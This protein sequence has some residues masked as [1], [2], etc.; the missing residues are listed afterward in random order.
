MSLENVKLFYARVAV[1]E[2]FRAQIQQLE[3]REEG[4][5]LA[6]A[7]GFDFTSQ[8][9]EDYTARVLEA[10]VKDELATIDAEEL[11]GVVGGMLGDLT[12]QDVQIYGSVQ[13]GRGNSWSIE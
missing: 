8:E 11:A 12:L 5:Q 6:K 3:R 13:P 10:D 1:D 7:M 4:Y 9:F 2:A